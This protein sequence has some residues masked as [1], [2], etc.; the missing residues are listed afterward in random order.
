MR[1]KPGGN[2]IVRM[3]EGYVS[4]EARFLLTKSSGTVISVIFIAGRREVDPHF[5]EGSPGWV[6]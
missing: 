3:Y 2:L 4:L 1:R 6:Y 5:F